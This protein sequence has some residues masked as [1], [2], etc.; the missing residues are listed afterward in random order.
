MTIFAK[1]GEVARLVM[2]ELFEFK[3]A[4]A[5]EVIHLVVQ[6]LFEFKVAL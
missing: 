3:V 4:E 2:Q 6:E 1:A 5:G